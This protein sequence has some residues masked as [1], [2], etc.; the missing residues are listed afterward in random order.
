[1]CFVREGVLFWTVKTQGYFVIIF[2]GIWFALAGYYRQDLK[3]TLH[4]I[5]WMSSS[6]SASSSNEYSSLCY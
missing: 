1:M 3:K 5:H 4:V 6:F 2:C